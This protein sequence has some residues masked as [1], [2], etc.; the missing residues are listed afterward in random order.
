VI[1]DNS[2]AH[3]TAANKQRLERHL[4][5]KLHFAPTRAPWQNSMEGWFTQLKRRA[6]CRGAFT[7]NADRMAAI[8]KFIETHNECSVK[9][10]KWN[11]TAKVII[12]LVH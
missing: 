12:S 1:L 10:L 5:L 11:K 6:L 7:S 8:H 4:H 9:P 2:S 3:R